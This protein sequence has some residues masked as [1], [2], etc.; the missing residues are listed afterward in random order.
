MLSDFIGWIYGA[1]V[2]PKVG[3][4]D[5]SKLGAGVAYAKTDSKSQPSIL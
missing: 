1:G 4:D 3:V 2:T 5:A